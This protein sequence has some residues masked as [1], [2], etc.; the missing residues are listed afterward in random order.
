MNSGTPIKKL[1]R[2]NTYRYFV[3][4]HCLHARHMGM[5]AIYC[6]I[7][8]NCDIKI[9][10]LFR[11]VIKYFLTLWLNDCLENVREM[12]QNRRLTPLWACTA[13]YRYSFAFILFLKLRFNKIIR[14]F[15]RNRKT[16]KT[17][18]LG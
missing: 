5:H 10:I 2:G 14:K 17:H 4:L 6:A 1:K 3:T 7:S 15:R 16:K 9:G 12:F 11:S 18:C 13:G 8:I